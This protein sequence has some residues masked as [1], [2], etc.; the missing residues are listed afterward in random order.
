MT[1][2]KV[3]CPLLIALTFTCLALADEQE[4]S[5]QAPRKLK[6]VEPSYPRESL[7]RGDEGMVILEAN[8]ETSGSVGR[9]RIVWSGCDRF[10]E[11]ALRAVRQWRF[12]VPRVNGKAVSAMMTVRLPFRLP[13]HLKSRAG[14]PGACTWTEGPTPIH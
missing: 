1:T 12:E 14:Q 13:E 2:T 8:I 11:A 10:N 3:A 5:I 7:R 6:H 4:S 9:A